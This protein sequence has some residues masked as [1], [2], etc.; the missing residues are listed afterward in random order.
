MVM[1]FN[2]TDAALGHQGMVHFPLSGIQLTE[3]HRV[4]A[5]SNSSAPIPMAAK[6]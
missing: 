5:Q 1:N 2:D 6:C 4:T 3:S